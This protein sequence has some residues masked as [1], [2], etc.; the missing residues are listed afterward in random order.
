MSLSHLL[1]H[2]LAIDYNHQVEYRC[3]GITSHTN[4]LTKQTA[5]SHAFSAALNCMSASAD[6]FKQILHNMCNI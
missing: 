2:C 4:K 6:S 3:A 5:L 1:Y